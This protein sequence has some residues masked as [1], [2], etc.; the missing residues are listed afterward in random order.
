MKNWRGD[1][2]NEAEKG[3]VEVYNNLLTILKDNKE[4]LK[5]LLKESNEITRIMTKAKS[6]SYINKY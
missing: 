3:L 6:S 4:E 5:R 2:L 1:E